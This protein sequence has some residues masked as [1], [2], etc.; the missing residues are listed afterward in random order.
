MSANAQTV[1]SPPLPPDLAVLRFDVIDSTSRLARREFESGALISP[2]PTLI[3][4]RDQTAAVGRFSRVW[5]SPTGG[6]WFTLVYPV[7]NRDFALFMK[8]LGLRV[9]VASLRAIRE[10]AR[11]SGLDPAPTPITLKWPNDV[12]VGRMKVLGALTEIVHRQAGQP[13][14]VSTVA[15][16]GIG[17]NANF[18]KA[19]LPVEVQSGGTT[20]RHEFGRDVPLDVLLNLLVARLLDA[21]RADAIDPETLDDARRHLHGARQPASVTMPDGSRRS[22]VLLDLNS[23]GLAVFDSPSGPFVAEPTSVVMLAAPGSSG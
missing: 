1:A 2:S 18:D 9:G 16:V 7:L 23:D 13:G 8:G 20:L 22:A 10:I 5:S 6:L 11:A 21:L 17:V 3:V 15:L 19:Q 14:G 12:L 4:A